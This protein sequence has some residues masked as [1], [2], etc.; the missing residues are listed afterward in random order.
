MNG[1][2]VPAQMRRLITSLLLVSTCA[3][4]VAALVSSGTAAAA[5]P[6][7]DAHQTARS[8]QTPPSHTI[9]GAQRLTLGDEQTGGGG[10]VDFWL[11]SLAGGDQVQFSV[12]EPTA[13][14]DFDL[15]APGT[16]D[17]DLQVTSPLD[18]ADSDDPGQVDLTLQA[19]YTG[20]FILAVCQQASNGDCST[21]DAGSGTDPMAPYTFTPTL[22][23]GGV[24]PADA[25]GEVQASP[26]ITGAPRLTIGNFEAGGGNHVDFWL[27]RLA[28][29]DQVQFDATV[30]T[31]YYDFDLYAPGT[32][33]RKLEVTS[34]LDISA[35]DDAAGQNYFTLRAPYTGT[36][37]LAVCQQA[38]N[39]D[40]ST[41]DAGSGT[42]PMGAYT[43]TPS[44]I[45]GPAPTNP[46]TTKLRLSA[47][48]VAYGKEKSLKFSV[49]VSSGFPG[50][51]SG[52]VTV[53]AGKQKICTIKLRSGKGGCSPT[54]SRQL[55][56]RTYSVTASYGG[57][58]TFAASASKAVAL[59]IRR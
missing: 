36:F 8:A 51:P 56:A 15:Y 30:P 44:I 26:T 46:T 54:S 55:A 4:M 20:T 34:P 19:P 11:I 41:T 31:A 45:S 38:S 43:F 40:C 53:R 17:G 21:T 22:V 3:A 13:Y 57:S 6:A 23:G 16:T 1:L 10:P 50:T 59:K 9:A 27:M 42:D 29:G 25:A 37:I 5:V 48:S 52:T 58:R 33:D 49:T 18:I 12:Q 2:A 39:G 24:S 7:R 14:Y 28:G 35:G 47:T 32:T